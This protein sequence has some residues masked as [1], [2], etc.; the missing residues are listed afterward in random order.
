MKG[1]LTNSKSPLAFHPEL[2]RAMVRV[3][4][5]GSAVH[6]R[7]GEFTA[8]DHWLS[9]KGTHDDRSTTSDPD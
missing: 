4:N 7:A 3:G 6:V 9:Q 8:R 2:E 5:E 1:M